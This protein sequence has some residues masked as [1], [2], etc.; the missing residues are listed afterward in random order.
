[1]LSRQN[2]LVITSPRIFILNTREE[3]KEFRDAGGNMASRNAWWF[4]CT[5][6]L[7]LEEQGRLRFQKREESGIRF[8]RQTR[9]ARAERLNFFS[10]KRSTS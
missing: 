3:E 2:E 9:R 8:I 7:L 6:L 10:Y 4:F 1:M 5:N